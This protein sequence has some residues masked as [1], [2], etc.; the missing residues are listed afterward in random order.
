VLDRSRQALRRGRQRVAQAVA[1]NQQPASP[2]TSDADAGARALRRV[3]ALR[4]DVER[5][6]AQLDET[7]QLSKRLAEVID[8]VAEVLLPSEQ[9]DEER[10]RA[11]LKDY[12]RGL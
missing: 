2:P 1:G 8:V 4:R 12:D 5:I 3:A 10:L 9:R 11:L 6:D 7:Q